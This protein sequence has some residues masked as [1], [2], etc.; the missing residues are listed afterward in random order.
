MKRHLAQAAVAAALSLAAPAFA[1]D[2]VTTSAAKTI[3][4]TEG[5]DIYN[6]ICSGCHM[7]DG[8]G[9]TGAGH[10]PALAGNAMLEG[11]DYPIHM[12]IHGQK[13]MP[14]VGDVMTDDQ[15]AAVVNYIRHDLGNAFEG[16]TTAAD[17]AAAR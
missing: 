10:Y 2:F 17:V 14:P 9:A 1:Q 5:K 7:P 6:A 8:T 15:I 16:E 11:P 4:G 12:I 3:P 13:A